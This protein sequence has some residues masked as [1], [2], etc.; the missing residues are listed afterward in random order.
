VQGVHW[1]SGWQF[2]A[3]CRQGYILGFYTNFV[4]KTAIQVCLLL[5]CAFG[6]G[7]C[8]SCHFKFWV[9]SNGEERLT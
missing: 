3:K 1:G 5:G 4:A 8:S 6:F 2:I 7:R 9:L